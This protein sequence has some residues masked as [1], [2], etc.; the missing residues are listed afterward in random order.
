MVIEYISESG[1][2]YLRYQIL[3]IGSVLPLLLDH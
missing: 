3:S 2:Y 1:I